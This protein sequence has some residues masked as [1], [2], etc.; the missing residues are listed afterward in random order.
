MFR[1]YRHSLTLFLDYR[2]PFGTRSHI[3]GSLILKVRLS[4]EVKVRDGER[5]DKE[6]ERGGR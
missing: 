6:E 2:G 5:E 3:I 1:R 4:K